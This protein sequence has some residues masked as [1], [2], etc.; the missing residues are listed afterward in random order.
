MMVMICVSVIQSHSFIYL[1]VVMGKQFI[2]CVLGF[3]FGLTSGPDGRPYVIQGG[4]DAIRLIHA[5]AK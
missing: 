1:Y 3:S 5:V 2:E 4:A